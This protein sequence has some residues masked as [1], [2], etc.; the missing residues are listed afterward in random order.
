MQC[1]MGFIPGP[2]LPL[3][4]K[5]LSCIFPRFIK[6]QGSFSTA[7]VPRASANCLNPYWCIFV[8]CLE[9]GLAFR[10]RAHRIGR[11]CPT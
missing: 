2:D 9:F 8:T 10:Y 3:N 6:D 4:Q 11:H 1:S 5:K 7:S